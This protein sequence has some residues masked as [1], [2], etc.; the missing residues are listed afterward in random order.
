MKILNFGFNIKLCQL[1][2]F[3]H[4]LYHFNYHFYFKCYL[5]VFLNYKELSI[6]TCSLFCRKI[7]PLKRRTLNVGKIQHT[8]F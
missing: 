7:N 5:I 4:V 6:I 3:L 1:Y 2:S 8:V